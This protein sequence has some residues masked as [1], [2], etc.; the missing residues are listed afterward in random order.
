MLSMQH[1]PVHELRAYLRAAA[2]KAHARRPGVTRVANALIAARRG[3]GGNSS[4]INADLAVPDWLSLPSQQQQHQSS[5]HHISSSSK[6]GKHSSRSS[7]G[8]RVAFPKPP[9]AP[10]K[11]KLVS[12]IKKSKC[13]QCISV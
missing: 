4:S 11:C 9:K 12:S 13:T 2:I 6:H 5:H 3:R 1:A 8:G 7:T 10:G